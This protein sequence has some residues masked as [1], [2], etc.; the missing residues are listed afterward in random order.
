MAVLNPCREVSDLVR[1]RMKPPAGGGDLW[2]PVP[3]RPR[4]TG[5]KGDDDR[6]L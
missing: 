1:K 4:E 2:V 3:A 5:V 6:S